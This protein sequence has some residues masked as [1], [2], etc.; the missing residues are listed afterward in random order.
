M[1]PGGGFYEEDEP[2]IKI[3]AAFEQ[4]TKGSTAASARGR[5][6]FLYLGGIGLAN[7]SRPTHNETYGQLIHH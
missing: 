6:E 3:V 4:G 7:F 1:E 5:T 2:V